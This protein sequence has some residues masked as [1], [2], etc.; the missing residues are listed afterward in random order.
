MYQVSPLKG[1]KPRVDELRWN[2]W[3]SSAGVCIGED[4]ARKQ[5]VELCAN[6]SVLAFDLSQEATQRAA[7]Q[8]SVV[9]AAGSSGRGTC[10]I[11]G[12][13]TSVTI[14]G[15]DQHVCCLMSPSVETACLLPCGPRFAPR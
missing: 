15:E 11:F 6:S 10:C 9:K 2:P 3:E 7:R 1:E 13:M 14:V 8:D 5:D 12:M 4:A